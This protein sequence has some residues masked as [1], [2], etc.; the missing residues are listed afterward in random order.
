MKLKTL[1]DIEPDVCQDEYECGFEN[2]KNE[3]K[4]EAIKWVKSDKSN[5][6]SKQGKEETIRW[7]KHFFNITEDDLK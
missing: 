7:I 5:Y 3:I 6:Y 1:K 2:C 4:E